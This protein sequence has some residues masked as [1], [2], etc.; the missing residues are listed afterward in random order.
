[1]VTTETITLPAITVTV[2]STVTATAEP[3]GTNTSP[4]TTPDSICPLADKTTITTSSNDAKSGR[5]AGTLSLYTI[6]CHTDYNPGYVLFSSAATGLQQCVQQCTDYTCLHDTECTAA[7]FSFGQCY[8]R[9]GDLKQY[10]I[11]YTDAVVLST[12]I[13]TDSSVSQGK[14]SNQ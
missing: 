10:A 6:H 9:S 4:T 1:M 7:T 12:A 8:G 13:I 14:D 3:D 5:P 2:V 11:D